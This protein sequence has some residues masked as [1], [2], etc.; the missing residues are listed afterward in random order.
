[1]S[2]KP[3]A[4]KDARVKISPFAKGKTLKE[5]KAMIREKR[6]AYK[7]GEEIGF[8]YVSSLKSQ[9]LIPR[10]DGTYKL[11]GKYKNL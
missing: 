1:M 6:A 8:T 10:A 11:G 5:A 2:S 7:K 9:G 4:V 3:F